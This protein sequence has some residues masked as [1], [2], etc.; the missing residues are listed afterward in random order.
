M[1]SKSIIPSLNYGPI[2]DAVD[3]TE[4]N[5]D[6]CKKKYDDVDNVIA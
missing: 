5:F 6:R 1:L 4:E 2:I 3:V